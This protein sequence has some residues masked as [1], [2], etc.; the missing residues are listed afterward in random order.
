[1][2]SNL[3]YFLLDLFILNVFYGTLEILDAIKTEFQS[4]LML[5]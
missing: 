2:F 5:N 3:A 4:L 1:M